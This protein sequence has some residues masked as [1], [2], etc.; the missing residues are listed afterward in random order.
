MAPSLVTFISGITNYQ[1]DHLPFCLFMYGVGG[2]PRGSSEIFACKTGPSAELGGGFVFL[3][4][5]KGG[6][7]PRWQVGGWESFFRWRPGFSGV[8]MWYFAPRTTDEIWNSRATIFFSHNYPLYQPEV[9]KYPFLALILYPTTCVAVVIKASA[10][11]K[12]FYLSLNPVPSPDRPRDEILISVPSFATPIS[13]TLS[14]IQQ[15][16]KKQAFYMTMW[17]RFCGNFFVPQSLSHAM[18]R[19]HRHGFYDMIPSIPRSYPFVFCPM[20]PG[21]STFLSRKNSLF[22]PMKNSRFPFRLFF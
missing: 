9:K 13:R 12:P 17:V 1:N 5:G 3:E 8:E 21:A 10:A 2:T 6:A 11:V 18:D 15:G 4:G 22:F 20:G 16:R 14:F 19:N 7:V